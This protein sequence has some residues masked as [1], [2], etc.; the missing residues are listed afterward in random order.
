MPSYFQNRD[1]TIHFL[2]AHCYGNTV[3]NC[4][5]MTQILG[6]Y[7]TKNK[8]DIFHKICRYTPQKALKILSSFDY[9]FLNF[10]MSYN[11][12]ESTILLIKK[13][14]GHLSDTILYVKI[15]TL[16]TSNIL[17]ILSYMGSYIRYNQNTKDPFN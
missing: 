8:D 6:C 11:S 4:E 12:V 13:I 16:S 5:T 9:A 15:M 3:M 14:G 2:A 10:V 7:Q 17:T 1:Q